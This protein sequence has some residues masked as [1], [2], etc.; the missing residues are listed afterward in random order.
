VLFRTPP[1]LRAFL[2]DA[3]QGLW[4]DA[5][6]NRFKACDNRDGSALTFTDFPEYA[7]NNFSQSYGKLSKRTRR[8][9]LQNVISWL[10]FR[11]S[12]ISGDAIV[13]PEV[14][15]EGTESEDLRAVLAAP[16]ASAYYNNR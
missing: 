1:C 16:I 5:R 8:E 3:G 14:P 6:E 15:P 11:E 2:A 12:L 7:R 9:A 13:A 4:Q 10:F